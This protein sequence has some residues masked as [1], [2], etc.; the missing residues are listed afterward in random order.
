MGGN[1]G[2]AGLYSLLN[3]GVNM[4]TNSLLQNSGVGTLDPK[5][6]PY[7]TGVASNLISSTLT[8]K[9][10]N[11]ENALM[12]TMMQQATST[13]KQALKTANVP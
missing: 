9:D 13:G 8:G 7:A 11:L 6:Q 1:A 10:P 4:G 3:S 12:K 2:D 5:I